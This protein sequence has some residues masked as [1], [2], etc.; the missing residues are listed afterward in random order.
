VRATLDAFRNL[1]RRRAR[2]EHIETI[3]PA[4]IPRFAQLGV[5]ASME[6]IHADPGTI[7]VWSRAVGQERRPNSFAWRALEKAG[8]GLVFSSDWPASIALDP[9]RG[10]HNAVNRRTVSGQPE[11]GW[12]PAQRVS[13]E[14]ALHAYTTAAAY[15]S[16]EEK[17]KGSI[18]PGKLADLVV[19]SR[20]LSTIP[21][22]EIHTARADLTLLG[23]KVVFRRY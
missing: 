21:P 4:D 22:I 11:A 10:L 1:P 8:A 6:P 3:N 12:L 20:D 23:G 2:I 9:I 17:V 18:E 14:T 13:L 15:A 5:L 19:L 7:E 16:I